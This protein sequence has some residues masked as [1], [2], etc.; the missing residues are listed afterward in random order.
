MNLLGPHLCTPYHLIQM[1]LQ[2][3]LLLSQPGAINPQAI[4]GTY[5]T[6]ALTIIKGSIGSTQNESGHLCTTTHPGGL[7]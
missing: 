6:T 3:S 7:G 1:T 2:G 5:S 4:P